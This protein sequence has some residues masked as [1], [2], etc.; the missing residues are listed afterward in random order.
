MW[1]VGIKNDKPVSSFQ[2]NRIFA[3]RTF[4]KQEYQLNSL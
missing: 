2:K 3:D 1:S 4:D